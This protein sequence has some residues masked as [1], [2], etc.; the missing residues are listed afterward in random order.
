MSATRKNLRPGYL[1]AAALFLFNPNVNIVDVLPDCIGY[2]FILRAIAGVSDLVPHFEEAKAAFRR[3][4]GRWNSPCD[5]E[6]ETVFA[7]ENRARL[8]QRRR[9]NGCAKLPAPLPP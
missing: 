1:I 3:P 5:A 2:L 6:R 9:R 4:T 7:S 8:W